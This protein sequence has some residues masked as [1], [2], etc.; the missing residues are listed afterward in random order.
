MY[1]YVAFFCFHYCCWNVKLDMVTCTLCVG[2]L[3]VVVANRCVRV[4]VLDGLADDEK[5][6]RWS[7]S[8]THFIVWIMSIITS[9]WIGGGVWWFKSNGASSRVFFGIALFDGTRHAM[10]TP[11]RAHERLVT[12]TKFAIFIQTHTLHRGQISEREWTHQMLCVG[13]FIY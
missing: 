12:K 7:R 8:E 10:S 3:L 6:P 13:F 1:L 5:K 2:L 9:R 4:C 11:L